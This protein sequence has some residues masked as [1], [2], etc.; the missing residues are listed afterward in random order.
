MDQSEVT[1][2]VDRNEIME[3]FINLNGG[4][5]TLVDYVLVAKRTQVEPASQPQDMSRSFAQDVELS[6]KEAIVEMLRIGYIGP[7]PVPE[8]GR[9][10]V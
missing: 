7:I 5:L 8:I 9:A 2:V 10:H 3:V 6:F 4:Q 1:L